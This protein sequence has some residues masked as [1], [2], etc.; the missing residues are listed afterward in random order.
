MKGYDKKIVEDFI[1]E[2]KKDEYLLVEFWHKIV[3]GG[4]VEG[5]VGEW[6]FRFAKLPG[7]WYRANVLF[8]LEEI[9]LTINKEVAN[10]FVAKARAKDKE[11]KNADDQD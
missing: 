3:C 6:Q 1:N 10:H 8:A 7:P 4:L 9:L 2:L 5:V 11:D